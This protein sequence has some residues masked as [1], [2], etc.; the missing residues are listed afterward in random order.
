MTE[1]SGQHF[2]ELAPAEL[3]KLYPP[4]PVSTDRKGREPLELSRDYT[5]PVPLMSVPLSTLIAE[6]EEELKSL[7]M[8]VKEEM[9]K[10][11]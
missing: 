7:L 6:S 2:Q 3:P 5:L 1:A 11:A 8:K 10:V 4:L 9:K